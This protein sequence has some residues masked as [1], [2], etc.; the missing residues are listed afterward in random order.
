MTAN[1][2]RFPITILL[3]HFRAKIISPSPEARSASP[4]D[5]GLTGEDVEI[6]YTSAAS[7]LSQTL[8]VS[9]GEQVQHASVR[10]QRREHRGP[11]TKKNDLKRTM[12]ASVWLIAAG[13]VNYIIATEDRQQRE[14]DNNVVHNSRWMIFNIVKRSTKEVPEYLSLDLIK[15]RTFQY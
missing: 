14:V 15:H 10:L 7:S 8:L 1:S 5:S 4:F 6:K 13:N 12:V 2:T 9:E 3:T 11:D